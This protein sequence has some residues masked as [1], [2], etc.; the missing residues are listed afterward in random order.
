MNVLGLVVPSQ[1]TAS[2]IVALLKRLRDARLDGSLG[3]QLP[4]TTGS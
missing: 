3:E 4:A 1:A 2:Q